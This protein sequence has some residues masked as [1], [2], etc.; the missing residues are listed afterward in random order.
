MFFRDKQA[1]SWTRE[2]GSYL[3]PPSD[4]ISRNQLFTHTHTHTHTR[5]PRTFECQQTNGGSSKATNQTLLPRFSLPR[6]LLLFR[7][8]LAKYNQP[9]KSADSE[10]E[11]ENRG[12]FAKKRDRQT[13]RI[14][15]LATFPGSL[16]SLLPARACVPA[17]ERIRSRDRLKGGAVCELTKILK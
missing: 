11:R 17:L 4:Q 10:R 8:S 2:L 7:D 13:L 5:N 9:P 12:K 3:K 1:L 15:K 14:C 16:L 6:I